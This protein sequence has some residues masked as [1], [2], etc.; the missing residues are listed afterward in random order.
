MSDDRTRRDVTATIGLAATLG[1]AGC[2]GDSGESG[3]AT[4]GSESTE[5]GHGETGEE[6]TEGGHQSDDHGSSLD[7]PQSSA[8]VS[9]A[10]TGDGSHFEPHVVWVEQ[11]G[12]VT[13]D[14]D[15]GTH[16]TTAYGSQDTPRRI[17]EGASTWDSGTVSETG[18]TFEQTFDTAG[19][20]DYYCAPHHATGMVGTVVVG[21]P[22]PEGQPGLESPQD[23]LPDA[24]R[25][26]IEELNARVTSALEGS[27]GTTTDDGHTDSGSDEGH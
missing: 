16:T 5:A 11:G 9:M 19:V 26:K 4:D 24:A 2:T 15:S 13:W 8:T 18:A 21:Q 23:S 12:T 25:T 7:G 10:T 3:T 14:L 17:P 6:S 1:L 27:N 20:Y 22:D